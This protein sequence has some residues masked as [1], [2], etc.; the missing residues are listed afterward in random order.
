MTSDS[1][2]HVIGLQVDI[3]TQRKDEGLRRRVAL[4]GATGPGAAT[5]AGTTDD[6]VAVLDR[7]TVVQRDIGV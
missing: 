5:S 2:R 4:E 3:R 1:R 6:K 7:G